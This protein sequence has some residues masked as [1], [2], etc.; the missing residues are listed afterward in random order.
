MTHPGSTTTSPPPSTSRIDSLV[1]A[2]KERSALGRATADDW[3]AIATIDEE[4]AR[5]ELLGFLRRAEPVIQFDANPYEKQPRAIGTV[6]GF[7]AGCILMALMWQFGVPWLQDAWAGID[8]GPGMATSLTYI[9]TLLLPL[10]AWIGSRWDRKSRNATAPARQER[11]AIPKD[12][13]FDDLI[14]RFCQTQQ[15]SRTRVY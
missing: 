13:S 1:T 15:R 6:V 8:Y 10:G 3:R 5:R 4:R 11:Q 2:A 12:T 14:Q 9:S 7:I